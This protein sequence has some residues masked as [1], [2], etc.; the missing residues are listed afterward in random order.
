MALLLTVDASVFVAACQEGEPAH[1]ASLALMWL[2]RSSDIPLVEPS[3]LPLE[4]GAALSRAGKEPATAR[5]YAES[6]VALPRLVLVNADRRAMQAALTM[7]VH[8]RLRAADALYM[9]VA[10]RYGA[11][12]VTLDREQLTR[13]PAGVAACRPSEA[14]TLVGR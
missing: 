6:I 12:L 10:A 5:A 2:L 3:I 1:A 7:A 11:R 13:A 4:V 8:Q 14:A 9:S